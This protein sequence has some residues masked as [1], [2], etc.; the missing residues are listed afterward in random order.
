[1]PMNKFDLERME[2]TLNDGVVPTVALPAH[3]ADKLILNQY[4][5]KIVPGIL[6]AAIRVTDKPLRRVTPQD[7]LIHGLCSQR[8]GNS[9]V[10]CQPNDAT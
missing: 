8:V 9:F 1:M 5:L 2:E 7:C 3:T 6:T 10:H 4:R